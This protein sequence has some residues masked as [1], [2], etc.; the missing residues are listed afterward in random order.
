MLRGAIVG[1]GNVA[2]HGHLPGW[3]RRRDVQIVAATDSRPEQRALLTAVAPGAR[4]C[5]STGELLAAAPLDFVDIC[6]PPSSHAPLIRSALERGLHVLCEKP[7][8]G[9]LD[10]L[11]PVA[12]LAAKTGCVLHTVHNWHYAPIVRRTAEL[13]RE[14]KIGAVTR[15]V[16]HTFRTRPAATGDESNGNWRVD[17]AVAGGGV[18]TD[19]GWHVFYVVPRWVGQSPRSVSARLERRRHVGWEVEDTAT[20]R[21][22]FASATAEVVLTW[23]SDE[24]KNWAE[25]TGSRG[26]LELQDDTLVLRHNGHGSDERWACPPAMSAGSHHPDWFDAVADQF[27]AEAAGRAPR[28]DNL[29]EAS[30]CVVLEH[31]ARASSREGGREVA[32]CVTLT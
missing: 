27:L 24:R 13:I 3:L 5:A 29:A 28:G 14:G 1:L 15:V 11:M 20:V 30:L 18:L 12:Q 7:L 19:H 6:T 16:W 23:A 21:V 10:D 4:W 25:V 22:T 31:G 32:V 2:V 9:S 8:V 17:P 26:V